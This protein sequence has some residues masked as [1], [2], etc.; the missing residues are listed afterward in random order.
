[1]PTSPDI[2]VMFRREQHPATLPSYA[3]RAEQMGF[4]QLWVVEDCFYLGGISQAAIALVTTST[5]K[6]GIGINPG[7][8]HNPAI[9]A[10]EYAT[11]ARAFPGRLIGGIGHGVAE[12]MDQI[13]VKPASWLTS[14]EEITSSLRAILRGEHVT[15]DGRSVQL[16]DVELF[17]APESV[18]PVLLGVRSEKSLRLAGRCA[19]GVLLAE[20]SGPDYVRWARSLMDGARREAGI[21]GAG[22]VIVYANS[23]VSDRDTDAAKAAMR[24]IV[25]GM[26]G[27]TLLPS[28]SPTS[29]AGEMRALIEQG[30]ADSLRQ[31]MPDSWLHDLAITGS[32]EDASES[33]ARLAQAGADAVV[34]VA[35]ET[36]DWD[37]WLDDQAWAIPR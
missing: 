13:G 20:S 32:R 7:V 2:G 22:E 11:L 4:D 19:D 31:H 37:A 27:S 36:V 21:P 5:I 35:P 17:E 23:L 33:V 3:Q 24:D 30:G 25:A 9:L 15:V 34:L 10:M 26:N 8:A 28:V 29:F 18:P 6:V 14:I 1:M 12:W 16:R